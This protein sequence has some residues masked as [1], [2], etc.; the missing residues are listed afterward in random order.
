MTFGSP[1]PI[2]ADAAGPPR[3]LSP[4]SF[5]DNRTS[6]AH[7]ENN[8]KGPVFDL[9]QGAKPAVPAPAKFAG[10]WLYLPDAPM[11]KRR[12]PGFTSACLRRF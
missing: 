7:E 4:V 12:R 5:G 9:A 3:L 8:A 1:G 2:L 10:A 11:L 6:L